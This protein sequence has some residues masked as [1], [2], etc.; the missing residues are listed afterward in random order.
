MTLSGGG[1][2]VIAKA[3][4]D[5]SSSAEAEKKFPGSQPWP[6]QYQTPNT[7]APSDFPSLRVC[8]YKQ[9][10]TFVESQAPIRLPAPG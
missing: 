9:A 8:H 3:E 1:Q 6:W 4:S 5:P 7:H 2:P 10:E